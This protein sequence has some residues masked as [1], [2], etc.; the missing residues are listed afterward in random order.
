MAELSFG[1]NLR[2]KRKEVLAVPRQSSVASRRFVIGRGVWPEASEARHSFRCGRL[3]CCFSNVAASRVHMVS[4]TQ[5]Q[6]NPTEAAVRVLFVSQHILRM[7]TL[8]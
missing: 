1:H 2:V 6:R 4:R 5:R 7:Q 8:Q 3:S